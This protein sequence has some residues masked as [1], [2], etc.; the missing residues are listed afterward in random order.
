[1]VLYFGIYG[2]VVLRGRIYKKACAVSDLEK[3]S[4]ESGGWPLWWA[5]AYA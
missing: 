1:M 5:L 4:Y 2:I 3:E